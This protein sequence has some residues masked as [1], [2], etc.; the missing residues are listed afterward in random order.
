MYGELG[1]LIVISRFFMSIGTTIRT[2]S[3]PILTEALQ[4]AQ[5]RHGRPIVTPMQRI[6]RMKEEE[7]I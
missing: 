2:E 6:R 5:A 3:S 7:R 1:V 4:K